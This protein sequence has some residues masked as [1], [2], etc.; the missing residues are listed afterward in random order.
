MSDR[1]KPR[2]PRWSVQGVLMSRLACDQSRSSSTTRVAARF[3]RETS[4]SSGVVV[5]V[6]VVVVVQRLHELTATKASPCRM[7]TRRKQASSSQAFAPSTSRHWLLDVTSSSK[8]MQDSV[9]RAALGHAGPRRTRSPQTTSTNIASTTPSALSGK[10]VCML[11]PFALETTGG[12]GASTASVYFLLTKQLR[13]SGLLADVLA[14]KLKKGISFALRCRTLAHVPTAL[15]AARRAVEDE[16]LAL[17]EAGCDRST[18][19]PPS[20]YED[21]LTRSYLLC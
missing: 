15:D 9:N 17:N 13:D 21:S 18:P 16:E 2:S 4:S 20:N 19:L 6:V 12:H 5:V 11:S 10:W 7:R 3:P 1:N 14:G 8:P